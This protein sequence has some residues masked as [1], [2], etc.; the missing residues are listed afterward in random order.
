MIR[1]YV[2]PLLALAGVLFAVWTAVQSARP[3]PPAA[4]VAEPPRPSFSNKISGSGIIEASTRNIAVGTHVPGIVSRVF[5]KVGERVKPGDPLFALDSR[6]Q[7][8]EL[9]VRRAALTEAQARLSRLA[10][11]PRPEELPV[12]KA[13]VKEAEAI[14]E[15]LRLQLKI[16]EGVTDRR[17]VSVEDMN[18]RRYAVAAAEA[19][20]VGA[21]SDLALL[22]AGSWEPDM[23]VARSDVARAQ[24]ELQAA[25]VEIERLTVYAPTAGEVLQMNIRPGEFAQSGVLPQPLILLGSVDRL[26]V[27]V[28]I[29]ENDAWRF[30]PKAPAVAYL[31][32]HSEYKTDLTF[33]YIESYVIPKRSLTG[34]STER[35]DTRVL[36]VV[37]SFPRE[38]LPIYPGQQVDVYI[39]DRTPTVLG[40]GQGGKK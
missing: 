8:A 37:Y 10:Q 1:K 30:S 26:H 40:E 7:Q 22:E 5:V 24:A 38:Q 20:L 12:A 28:D 17:A 23:D 18:K 3:I 21:R 35:V 6:K 2:L 11:T 25:Q 13:R 33:E 32:G 31:R 9:A 16:L 15:D 14:V 36:Q 34:D 4:P 27:R 39:E 29:D 19:R